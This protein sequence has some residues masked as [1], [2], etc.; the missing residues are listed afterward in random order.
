MRA[1]RTLKGEN[2]AHAYLATRRQ[3]CQVSR[4][5]RI[6]FYIFEIP[7]LMWTHRLG[8]TL[9]ES[10][11]QAVPR[12]DRSENGLVRAWISSPCLLPRPDCLTS[13]SSS[14][15]LSPPNYD[16]LSYLDPGVRS[17]L[18]LEETF[19]RPSPTAHP[20]CASPLRNTTHASKIP[21][22][23]THPSTSSKVPPPVMPVAYRHY[24][25]QLFIA[26]RSYIS[27]RAN[28]GVSGG[29]VTV[30]D[31]G[32]I[33]AAR[34][35]FARAQQ[36]V[37]AQEEATP[38]PVGGEKAMGREVSDGRK[39]TNDEPEASR[40]ASVEGSPTK[41]V[42]AT[43]LGVEVG[44]E[45]DKPREVVEEADE[46]CRKDLERLEQMETCAMVVLEEDKKKIKKREKQKRYKMKL[47]AR[48]KLA[49]SAH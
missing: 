49:G 36:Q 40:T 10:C 28:V 39:R 30:D 42:R 25:D 15:T 45:V 2:R 46:A 20:T 27:A 26:A 17:A 9:S 37:T 43:R 22:N 33:E 48:K 44:A 21:R 7:E 19:T 35:A 24:S 47:K 14:P 8:S 12:G 31:G 3:N 4:V 34:Q 5:R 1:I 41:R 6:G 16:P 11:R 38:A 29:I 13:L 32:F 18:N 23:P